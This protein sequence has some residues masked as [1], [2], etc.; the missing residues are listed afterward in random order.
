MLDDITSDPQMEEKSLNV[1]AFVIVDEILGL[2]L[3]KP[4]ACK[5]FE[6]VYP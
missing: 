1:A 6:I 4:L 5:S 3:Q 2:T